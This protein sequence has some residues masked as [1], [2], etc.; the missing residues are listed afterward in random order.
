MR[1]TE[2]GEAVRLHGEDD[3]ERFVERFRGLEGKPVNQVEV[4]GAVAQFAH[5]IHGLL[6]HLARLDAVNGLLHLGVK[7]L[8]AHRGA[9]EADL[10]QRHQVFAGEPARVHFHTGFHVRRK[11]EVLVDDF[12]EA[13]NFVRPQKCWRTASEVKLHGL[14]LLVEHGSHFC[15]LAAQRLH[16][17]HALGVVERDDRGATTKPTKRLTKR[18]VEINRQVTRRAVVFRNLLRKLVPRDDVGKFGGRRIAGITRPGHVVFPHQIQ[19]NVQS[20]HAKMILTANG[21]VTRKVTPRP[22]P[23]P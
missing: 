8:H 10:A 6:G 22:G 19:V 20:F 3:V 16:V 23:C 12:A 5:P 17:G 9:V 21:R 2:N 11:G 1:V 14:A 15:H 4:D 7:I 18:N 13:A